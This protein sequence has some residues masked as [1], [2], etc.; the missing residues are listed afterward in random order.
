VKTHHLN[1]INSQV[2]KRAFY[3]SFSVTPASEVDAPMRTHHSNTWSTRFAQW[4][5]KRAGP[6]TY[7]HHFPV[8]WPSIMS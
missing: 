3:E 4:C 7:H 2:S 6:G 8:R 5:V 1:Y